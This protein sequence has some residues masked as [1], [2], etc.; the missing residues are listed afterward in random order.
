MATNYEKKNKKKNY[1]PVT[2][3]WEKK[4]N[5]SNADVGFQ[6]LSRDEH[7]RHVEFELESERGTKNKT[8]VFLAC[9]LGL[10]GN[11][12]TIVSW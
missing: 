2:D 4:R 9:S 8:C 7:V 10:L 12:P 6:Q 3:T 5:S 11:L 1:S